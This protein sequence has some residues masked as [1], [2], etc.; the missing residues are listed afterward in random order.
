MGVMI[1]HQLLSAL[2]QSFNLSFNKGFKATSTWWQYVAM[3]VPSDTEEEVYAWLAQ[4]PAVRKWIGERKA[5]RLAANGYRLRNE[6][7]EQ[8]VEVERNKIEDDKLMLFGN[9]FE[10][11]GE[12]KAKH[13]DRQIAK[14]LIDGTTNL[15]WDGQAFFSTGHPVDVNAEGAGS[16]FD[17]LFTSKALTPD[18]FEDVYARMSA[19]KDANGNAMTVL[20]DTIFVP[21]KL[22]GTALRIVKAGVVAV[23]QGSGAAAIDNVN[24]DLVDVVTIPELAA[25]VGGS[26]TTWYLGRCKGSIKPLIRQMR[27]DHGFQARTDPNSDNV[28]NKK[29]Y[30][31]GG[32]TREA[33][34]Y[35]L[36]Q[37]LARCEQ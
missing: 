29:T 2:F 26:D 21:P 15:G 17:N 8:T 34:G 9:I 4:L 31:Y 35:S 11:L 27:A 23:T 28:F 16:S 10:A 5:A 7:W 36:P 33:F 6:D 14:L 3:Q 22:R 32:D 37:L 20:P 1:T 13:P 25:A 19:I 12:E 24:K 18:N 30:E